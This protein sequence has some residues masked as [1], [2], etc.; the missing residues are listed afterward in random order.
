MVSLTLLCFMEANL[1]L[2]RPS[3]PEGRL[4]TEGSKSFSFQK[5]LRPCLQNVGRAGGGEE[6]GVGG[7]AIPLF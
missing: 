5:G 2:C 3:D 7:N 4:E 1:E 6:R